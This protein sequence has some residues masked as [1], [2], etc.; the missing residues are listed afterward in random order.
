M[1]SQRHNNL[2]CHYLHPHR[3]LFGN[4][5]PPPGY[6]PQENGHYPKALSA[7]EELRQGILAAAAASDLRPTRDGLGATLTELLGERL[8]QRKQALRSAAKDKAGPSPSAL[9]AALVHSEPSME[10]SSTDTTGH[11]QTGSDDV[12]T[13]IQRRAL[14]SDKPP[15]GPHGPAATAP[16]DPPTPI[17][18][19][20]QM[21]FMLI[22]SF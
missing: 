20:I 11:S 1:V 6:D 9:R 12:A 14:S 17:P 19:M 3:E 2:H 13:V 7:A 18:I 8:E 5:P 16:V 10:R 4:T 15:A 21:P 22:Y